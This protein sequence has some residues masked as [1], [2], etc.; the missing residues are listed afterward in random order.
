MP[1]SKYIKDL[2]VSVGHKPLLT[3]GVDAVIYNGDGHL[4]L[5]KRSDTGLWGLPGDSSTRS[6][7]PLWVSSARCLK[8]RALR[9][10]RSVQVSR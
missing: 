5:I 1:I 4:L 6:S 8:K 3:P 7:P 2:R 9:L 10:D